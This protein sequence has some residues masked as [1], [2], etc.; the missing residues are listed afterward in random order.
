MTYADADTPSVTTSRNTV[1]YE[2]GKTPVS[3]PG[4]YPITNITTP[5]A[6]E[7][8]ASIGP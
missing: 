5:Q 4:K 7:A 8:C 2:D 6:R 1:L 3:M